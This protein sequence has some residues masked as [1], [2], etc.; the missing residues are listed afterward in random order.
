[1]CVCVFPKYNNRLYYLIIKKK[2]FLNILLK[3]IS[4]KILKKFNEIE[5][6]FSVYFELVKVIKKNE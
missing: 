3:S 5:R 2:K 1:M 4:M 6:R